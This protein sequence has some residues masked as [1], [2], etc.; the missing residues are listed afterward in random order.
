MR[1]G[2]GLNVSNEQTDALPR[3]N[4]F[5]NFVDEFIAKI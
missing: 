3:A 1:V 2:I 5:G 4:Y